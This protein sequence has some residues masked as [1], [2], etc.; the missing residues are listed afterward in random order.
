MKLIADTFAK[1]F[2]HWNIHHTTRKPEK[3]TKRLHKRS[4]QASLSVPWIIQ[5]KL[6]IAL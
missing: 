1:H 4:W 3:Q 2:S 5:I 6:A